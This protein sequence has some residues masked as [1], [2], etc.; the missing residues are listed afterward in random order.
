MHGEANG[1]LAHGPTTAQWQSWRG[2]PRWLLPFPRGP[3][4]SVKTALLAVPIPLP[5]PRFFC[6]FTPWPCS[7]HCL[8]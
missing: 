2:G 6:T 1:L 7:F 4:S 3:L 8:K 5:N